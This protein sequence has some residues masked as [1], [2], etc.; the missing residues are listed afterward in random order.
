VTN[1][2]IH[3]NEEYY[4]LASAF[5]Q[6]RP[7][8][9]LSHAESFSIYD[10][11]GDIPRATL[12]SYGLFHGG[13]RFLSRYELRVNGQWP[14]V[15][16]TVPTHNGSVLTTYLTNPDEVRDGTLI[17]QR[18]IVAIIRRKVLS[19]GTLYEQLQL[20]NYGRISLP[21]VLE[22][23][24]DADFVD[25]F[26]IRGTTRSQRGD[27]LPPSIINNKLYLRY[28]GRDAIQRTTVME[29][30][31]TPT[32]LRANVARFESTLPPA[33]QTI[34]EIR[35]AC[36]VEHR[37]S[38]TISFT[39]AL[40]AL[41]TER[42]AWHQQF[43]R[44][45][46][47]NQD[48]NS[49]LH[50]SLQ[51]L[52]LLRVHTDEGSYMNAGIPW[53]ATLF[54]RDSL[55]TALET[56]AFM[57]ELAAGTLRTLAQK[58]GIE[59]NDEQDEEVGKILHERRMGE[60]ATLR[61]IPFGQYYGSID[62][63]PLFLVL[64]AE[65]VDRTGDLVLARELWP[66]ALAAMA[67]I[68][69][70][71]DQN[72]YLAYAR[73]TPHG[74]INQGWK[75]SH[76]AI[77]H[78]DGSLAE[79]PIAL[80]EVQAYL[81]AAYRGVAGIAR[82]LQYADLAE[83]W[84]IQAS[85]LQERFNREFWW[86]EEGT[87]A[88]ARDGAGQLCHVVSSNAGHCLF[89][90]IASAENARQLATRLSRKDMF[91]GW[92]IRTL[93]SQ[94]VRYNPMSYHNGSVWPHDNALIA[95]GLAR[96]G[97]TTQACSLLSALFE[98]S[99]T[100]DDRRLPELF[101]GFSHEEQQRPVPYPVAC[102]PQA[103]AAGSVFLL[104]QAALDLRLNVWQRRISFERIALPTWLNRV[105]IYGLRIGEATVDLRITRGRWS[106]GVEVMARQ[107]EVD[108]IVYK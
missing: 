47:D 14:F 42:E 46:S 91:C 64:L 41:S 105:E 36:C 50:R 62:A 24:I 84:T 28:H 88:L 68:T 44:I 12:Q 32:E 86:S 27:I 101:C 104:L 45:S 19:Q 85:R 13:T 103:W 71:V 29:F 70:T 20:H 22:F 81:Y 16:S 67:W 87:F 106:A 3:L 108:V 15:L 89:A 11:A 4:L 78:R 10:I 95:A 75:D 7:Q 8:V 5:L 63:T 26:E 79:P 6:R 65:Y 73:R 93:S 94:E 74:L 58:Q 107:G 69:K 99:R 76:D 98:V 82:R 1:E 25:I 39:E 31:P 57:P 51:D 48:F 100:T 77:V 66:N 55:I 34:L 90:G 96:Y 54:G 18:D 56:L 35:T 92:G 30:F 53:F 17:V 102:R 83:E 37:P 61:E 97:E 21:L 43:P 38:P 52:T 23:T 33:G 40:T 9:L 59:V 49:W 72:G 80:A 2:A 60:M